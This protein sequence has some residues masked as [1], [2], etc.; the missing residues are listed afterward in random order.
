MNNKIRVV[1]TTYINEN[2]DRLNSLFCSVH[3][4][5]AQTYQN[6]E[7][8][9]R[10]DGP[11]LIDGLKDKLEKL[12][13]KI[14]VIDDGERLQWWG[15]PY[16]HATAII[17][18]QADWIVYANDDNY[19]MPVF[20]EEMLNAAISTNSG[21]VYCNLV[22]NGFNYQVLDSYPVSGKIDQGSFM[23]RM[24]IINNTPWDNIYAPD[25]D[26]H[27][28]EKIA[29]KTNTVKLNKILFVHN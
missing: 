13:D 24:D 25:A 21:M 26:G 10:H 28:V 3:S 17:E 16:R 11:F 22:H 12:S 18:P 5:L 1:L 19:H 7:I 4:I 29:A 23:T 20:L 14:T 6:F 9:I 8:F 15:N 2:E 27:Y